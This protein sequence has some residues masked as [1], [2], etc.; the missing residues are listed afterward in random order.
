ML[1]WL[2]RAGGQAGTGAAPR[3]HPGGGVLW[4]GIQ[5]AQPTSSFP[6]PPIPSAPPPTAEAFACRPTTAP[7]CVL[8]GQTI[9][10]KQYEQCQAG[11]ADVIQYRYSGG[12]CPSE[13]KV[14]MWPAPASAPQ[15]Q[16]GCARSRL[17]SAPCVAAVLRKLRVAQRGLA[18]DKTQ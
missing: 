10:R 12:I 2:D 16:Q 6:P 1:C 7:P 14:R 13:Y 3:K 15:A 5:A 9:A 8:R 11:H 4:L 17:C 18:P